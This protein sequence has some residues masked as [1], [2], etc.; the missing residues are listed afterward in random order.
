M[1]VVS[2][3]FSCKTWYGLLTNTGIR[4]IYSDSSTPPELVANNDAKKFNNSSECDVQLLQRF[5]M[6]VSDVETYPA[7]AAQPLYRYNEVIK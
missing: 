2:Y 7:M 3:K 6:S 5:K 1:E 4:N